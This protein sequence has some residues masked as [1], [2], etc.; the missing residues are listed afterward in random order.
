MIP[1]HPLTTSGTGIIIGDGNQYFASPFKLRLTKIIQWSTESFHL[2][3]ARLN[4]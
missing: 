3:A 4:P 2:N 1:S